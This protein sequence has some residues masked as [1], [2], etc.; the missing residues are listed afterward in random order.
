MQATYELKKSPDRV[1]IAGFGI[2]VALVIGGAGGY[3]VKGLTAAAP[4][5]PAATS[6]ISAGVASQ[7][8][9]PGF[10]KRALRLELKDQKSQG[11]SV[12]APS[13]DFNHDS[14]LSQ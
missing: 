10:A 7:A 11:S 9:D 3:A 6:A 8:S 12:A 4:A 13:T 5:I 2:L 1:A 14:R